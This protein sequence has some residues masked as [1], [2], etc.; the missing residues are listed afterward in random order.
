MDNYQDVY[1]QL[2]AIAFSVDDKLISQGN[3]NN[4]KITSL[5]REASNYYLNQLRKYIDIIK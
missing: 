2:Q 3:S 5:P 1:N 4:H